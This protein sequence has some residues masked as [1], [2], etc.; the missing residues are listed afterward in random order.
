MFSNNGITI[1]NDN[2]YPQINE[3]QLIYFLLYKDIH[4]AFPSG[5]CVNNECNNISS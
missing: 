1:V 4:D 2:Y 3:Q 5:R